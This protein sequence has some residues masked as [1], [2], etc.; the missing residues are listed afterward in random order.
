MVSCRLKER[1]DLCRALETRYA[2]SVF[3]NALSPIVQQQLAL[4]RGIPEYKGSR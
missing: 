2:T 4:H 1:Q 3:R